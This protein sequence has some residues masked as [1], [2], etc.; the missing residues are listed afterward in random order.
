[1]P[2]W[3]DF[4]ARAL[5][6]RPTRDFAQPPGVVIQRID[7]ASGLL[8]APGQEANTLD[9]VFLPDTAPTA[10]ASAAGEETS[11]DKLLLDR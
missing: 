3:T 11:A 4:M 9:E 6:G 10:Q 8:A 1:L 2:I 5:V 7:K